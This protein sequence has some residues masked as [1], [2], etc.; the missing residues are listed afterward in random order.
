MIWFELIYLI[1]LKSSIN[2]AYNVK[3]IILL[4]FCINRQELS[5]LEKN[6]GL[7]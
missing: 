5:K 3:L 1:K 7:W 4:Q 2:H 6:N